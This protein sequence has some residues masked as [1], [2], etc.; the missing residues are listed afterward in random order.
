MKDLFSAAVS[1]NLAYSFIVQVLQLYIRIRNL[2]NNTTIF[3]YNSPGVKKR[4]V[5]EGEHKNGA[6]NVS[7]NI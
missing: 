5:F 3:T 2:Q 1:L 7:Y 4:L 6:K